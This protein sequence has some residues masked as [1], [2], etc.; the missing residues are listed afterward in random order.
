M[1][2]CWD[3]KKI[4]EFKD[5]EQRTVMW[6]NKSEGMT[7]NTEEKKRGEKRVKEAGKKREF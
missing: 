1:C 4:S 5:R 7:N 3:E 6:K 2:C